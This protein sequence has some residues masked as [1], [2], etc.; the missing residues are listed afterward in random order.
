[1]NVSDPNVRVERTEPPVEFAEGVALPLHAPEPLP[2]PGNVTIGVCPKQ[3][4][5]CKTWAEV[6]QAVTTPLGEQPEGGWRSRDPRPTAVGP[7]ADGMTE[8]IESESGAYF[9]FGSV[10]LGGGLLYYGRCG[11]E[12]S[13]TESP[14][15]WSVE[16][17]GFAIDFDRPGHARWE[18]AEQAQAAIEALCAKFEAFGGAVATPAYAFVTPSGLRVVYPFRS[19]HSKAVTD[20][21]QRAV[22]EQ[23]VEVGLGDAGVEIDDAAL[24]AERLSGSPY[25]RREVRSRDDGKPRE[26]VNTWELPE[27]ADSVLEFGEFID[28]AE[29]VDVE[30][31]DSSPMTPHRRDFAPG[32]P[33]MPVQ[34][35]HGDAGGWRELTP[36]ELERVH[37]YV[38]P[39]L[40]E[41]IQ[42]HKETEKPGRSV[43][44][45]E[46]PG[47]E[48]T[49]GRNA[50][51]FKVTAD[52]ANHDWLGGF[53]SSGEAQGYYDTIRTNALNSG[54]PEDEVEKAMAQG[55][56]YGHAKPKSASSILDTM[57]VREEQRA[58]MEEA[59]RRNARV[60]AEQVEAARPA[61][62]RQP[63][64]T[65]MEDDDAARDRVERPNNGMSEDAR[66]T[67]RLIDDLA[68]RGVCFGTDRIVTGDEPDQSAILGR[69]REVVLPVI[70]RVVNSP[71]GK[72][73]D[74][75]PQ[76][77]DALFRPAVLQLPREREPEEGWR[78]ASWATTLELWQAAVDAREQREAEERI[79]GDAQVTDGT[80]LQNGKLFAQQVE[81][82]WL[83]SAIHERWLNYRREKGVW[84]VNAKTSAAFLGETER[85]VDLIQ[86]DRDSHEQARRTAQACGDEE[87]ASLQAALVKKAQRSYEHASSYRGMK[88]MVGVAQPRLETSRMF[89]ERPDLLNSANGTFDFSDR[90]IKFRAHDPNDR[91]TKTTGTIYDPDAKAPTFERTIAQ[92]LP[93][94]DT[95]RFFQKLAGLMLTGQHMEELLVLIYGPGGT[96]KSTT[97]GIFGD[98]MGDYATPVPEGVFT[99]SRRGSNPDYAKALL[100][101]MRLATLV[102]T[103][104][105]N[106]WESAAVK[107]ATGGDPMTARPI[108]GSPITFRPQ[109]LL[110]V[111]TNDLPEVEDRSDG[112]WR[113]AKLIHFNVQFPEGEA[114]TELRGKLRAE[115]SGI[116][117]WALDGLRMYFAEGLDTPDAVRRDVERYRQETDHVGTF[118]AERLEVREGAKVASSRMFEEWSA[119]ARARN[120]DPGSL[121]K[122]GQQFKAHLKW[123]K[124]SSVFYLDVAFRSGALHEFPGPKSALGVSNRMGGSQ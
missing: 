107:N 102:E 92:Q 117:N 48:V 95:R 108:Y 54:L 10:N 68:A 36:E 88:A 97:L 115:M 124:N 9:H 27:V 60:A 70:E 3:A 83:Y 46:E 91:L 79:A 2:D 86:R 69:V 123:A 26:I 28:P 118:I 99:H 62:D 73:R 59:I 32:K 14:Q 67:R 122:C 42:L 82:E 41:H 81:G 1:M 13:K 58:G 12:L 65:T 85:T 33:R 44:R 24:G 39:G 87:G 80:D 114:D 56:T 30:A 116:L 21:T 50:A 75:C 37:R 112:F 18:S 101:G 110:M 38:T 94:D 43:G 109:F 16:F 84:Q 100:Q 55:M 113:R 98:M 104:S 71:P 76:L 66:A 11:V 23:F 61:P 72:I 96:G 74:K 20:A 93:H 7:L 45:Q 89:D 90:S 22:Y 111:A 78:A 29:F 34:S 15:G 105:G 8:H 63:I 5:A 77:V 6:E 120:V 121:T 106:A 19:A 40:A 17:M 119:W 35:P 49:T 51:T 53:L 52:I 47:K 25:N 31:I 64:D 57:L 4:S 103:S